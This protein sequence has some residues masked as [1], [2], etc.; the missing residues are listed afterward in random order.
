VEG[1]PCALCRDLRWLA[2]GHRCTSH[3]YCAGGRSSARCKCSISCREMAI[4]RSSWATGGTRGAL[5]TRVAAR[6]CAL[7]PTVHGKPCTSTCIHGPKVRAAC[8]ACRELQQLVQPRPK[9]GHQARARAQSQGARAAPR[10]HAVRRHVDSAALAA[11]QLHS[12]LLQL[13][14]LC[15]CRP[16]MPTSL[17]LRRASPTTSCVR[18]E[19]SCGKKVNAG[20]DASDTHDGRG[21][22][23]TFDEIDATPGQHA[24]STILGA[25]H[26]GTPRHTATPGLLGLHGWLWV[27]L[28]TLKPLLRA[29]KKGPIRGRALASANVADSETPFDTRLNIRVDFEGSISYTLVQEDRGNTFDA[30]VWLGRA[31]VEGRDGP[32]LAPRGGGRFC[33]LTPN[34][35]YRIEVVGTRKEVVVGVAAFGNALKLTEDDSAAGEDKAS[36]SCLWRQHVQKAVLGVP[37]PA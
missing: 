28:R 36:C 23:L 37:G 26:R 15:C 6:I 12:A 27:A 25:A 7:S 8:E 18:Y 29:P 5:L 32:P 35:Q 20:F 2:T 31:R 34:A 19:T 10:W 21:F 3:T 33:E 30:R 13:A 14:T 22:T 4:S 11:P 17:S 9:G 1:E 16:P 24:E